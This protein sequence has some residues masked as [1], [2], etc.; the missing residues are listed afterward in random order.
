MTN[1]VS[2]R[3]GNFISKFLIWCT[4]VPYDLLLTCPKIEKIK[5]EA[6]GAAM[7]I[8]AVAGFFS[9]SYALQQTFLSG[10]PS[11][12][13]GAIYSLLIFTIERILVISLG[14]PKDRSSYFRSPALYLRILLAA[15][16]AIVIAKPLEMRIFEQTISEQ[17][18]VQLKAKKNTVEEKYAILNQGLIDEI[19][20]K[21]K[22]T[23]D[24]QERY[25]DEVDGL[26]STHEVGDG[27]I[28]KIKRA[29][30]TTAK[31]ELDSLKSQNEIAITTNQQEKENEISRI[32]KAHAN[33]I[34][35][36]LRALGQAMSEND[37]IKWT[38]W[39]LTL[40]LLIFEIIPLMSKVFLPAG[41]LHDAI[42]AEKKIFEDEQVVKV[43]VS[44]SLILEKSNNKRIEEECVLQRERKQIE[45]NS[46]LAALLTDIQN[47]REM[48]R[49]IAQREKEINK[50]ENEERRQKYH[51]ELKSFTEAYYG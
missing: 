34:P 25:L 38:S 28:A 14:F 35:A 27:P 39:I 46:R 43:R 18:D 36:R 10:W 29:E 33:D 23:R 30:L 17:L 49:I 3:K 21:E 15:V 20:D 31:H 32:Q 40:F 51:D 37:Y 1:I 4:G 7:L 45:S 42:E 5:Y 47:Q 50:V 19:Q 48:E 2:K 41:P 24:L 9:G 8:P 26:S 11:Y 12:V 13:G 44:E 22:L 16:I 6:F